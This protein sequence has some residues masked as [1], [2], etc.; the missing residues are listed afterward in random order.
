MSESVHCL[1][2]H[3]N[4]LFINAVHFYCCCQLSLSL[5][6]RFFSLSLSLVYFAHV[7]V[8]LCVCVSVCVCGKEELM[9]KP[10]PL[11]IS[12]THIHK[13]HHTHI[14]NS[15]INSEPFLFKKMSVD[16]FFH[17]IYL[18]FLL[19]KLKPNANGKVVVAY[20]F[21]INQLFMHKIEIREQEKHF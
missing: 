18:F 3:R 15:Q 14:K 20:F 12:L 19:S 16:F 6:I 7:F 4:F 9:H 10:E 11:Q 1:S 21:Y 2:R 5:A 13:H 8:C 17:F